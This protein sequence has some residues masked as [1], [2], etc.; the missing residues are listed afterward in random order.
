MKTNCGDGC[1]EELWFSCCSY[2]GEYA[3]TANFN[4][5]DLVFRIC[6][7]LNVFVGVLKDFV[8][9]LKVLVGAIFSSYIA[10]FTW[11]SV[12]LYQ[13]VIQ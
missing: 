3:L 10:K 6:R 4:L 11:L 2:F 12:H 5:C 13:L 7:R 9:V 1:A 8:G